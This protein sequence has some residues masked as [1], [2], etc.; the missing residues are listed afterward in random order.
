[1][2][3]FYPQSMD[4]R[5]A[6]HANFAAQLP[7]FAVKYNIPAADTDYATAVAA[8][9]AAWAQIRHL[10]DTY[11]QQVTKYFNTIAGADR[12]AEPPAKPN[13]DPIILLA[14]DPI[15]GV[16]RWVIDLATVIK[17]NAAYAPADGSAMGINPPVKLAL[18]PDTL[19][20]IIE[21]STRANFQVG[22]KFRKRGMSGIRLE[23]RHAGGD[24]IAAGNLITSPGHF[25][26]APAIAGQPE[27]IE[28]R[29]IYLTG[30]EPTGTYSDIGGVVIKS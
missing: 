26:V 6:W 2:A 13:F 21:L 25:D 28:V 18:S 19:Q 15:P 14:P 5:N 16:E 9:Y 10:L 11:S 12:G 20:P 3:D 22:V 23:Y 24:W 7:S 8:W 1:M 30:N 4:G 29:A 17:R 27:E